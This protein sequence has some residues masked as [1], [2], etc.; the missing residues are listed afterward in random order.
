IRNA[1]QHAQATRIT[2]TLEYRRR[3]LR[4][5]IADDGVGI[6]E[7][8]KGCWSRASRFGLVGMRER[9]VQLG[10]SFSIRGNRPGGTSVSVLVPARHAFEAAPLML[11]RLRR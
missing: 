4:M 1:C 10:A 8:P 6:E 7:L 3:S 11:W 2:V 5:T 9:A